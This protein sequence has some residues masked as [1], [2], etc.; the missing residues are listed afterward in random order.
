MRPTLTLFRF[1]ALLPLLGL[2]VAAAGTL[3]AATDPAEDAFA[4]GN[5]AFA[6]EDF[7]AAVVAYEEAL[8]EGSS[9][10]LHYNLGTAH[11]RLEQWGWASLH[12]LKTLAL[13]PNRADARGQ[14]ALVRQRSGL[15]WEERGTIETAAT[16]LPLGTWAWLGTAAFWAC[17][18]LWIFRPPGGSLLHLLARLALLCVVA[19]S[20]GALAFYHS[21]GQRGVVL[22]T[23][24]LRIAPTETS[25]RGIE[26][27][28]GLQGDVRRKVNGFLLVRTERGDEGYLSPNEFARVWED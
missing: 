14:L 13:S 7:A 10:N 22:E 15:G 21:Q 11:A 6:R 1:P 12:L 25:P 4:R 3:Q 28:A 26:L 18:F 24:A 27:E 5:A 19:L 2:F 16:V 17:V 9:P 23:V 8:R 20:V